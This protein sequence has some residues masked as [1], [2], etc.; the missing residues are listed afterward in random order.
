[1]LASL[2]AESDRDQGHSQTIYHSRLKDK[3]KRY[4]CSCIYVHKL[5]S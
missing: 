1:M 3:V 2:T 5:L 4:T